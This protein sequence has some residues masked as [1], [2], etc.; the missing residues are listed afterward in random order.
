MPKKKKETS[1][2]RGFLNEVWQGLGAVFKTL[3]KLINLFAEALWELILKCFKLFF[4]VWAF[5]LATVLTVAIILFLISASIRNI[6]STHLMQQFIQES[7]PLIDLYIQK[8]QKNMTQE[9]FQHNIFR[10]PSSL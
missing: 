6:G 2:A 4:L 7:Q 5:A 8:F 3:G 10:D 9:F 1:T